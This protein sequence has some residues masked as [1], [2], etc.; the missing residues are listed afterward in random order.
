MHDGATSER[1]Y[2]RI[3]HVLEGHIHTI[4][5]TSRRFHQDVTAFM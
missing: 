2:Y 4:P 5:H 3:G 1:G